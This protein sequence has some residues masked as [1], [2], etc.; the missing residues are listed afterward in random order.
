VGGE[1]VDVA[2]NG[3]I[4]YL[5]RWNGSAWSDVGSNDINS[6]VNAL[7]VY[8]GEL[9]VGG[10]FTDAAGNPNADYIAKWSGECYYTVGTEEGPNVPSLARLT[11]AHALAHD[12]VST[13]V[14]ELHWRT[15]YEVDHL[16]FHVYREEQGQRVRIT[17]ALIAGSALTAGAKTVLTAGQSYS[18]WDVL[19]LDSGPLRY[20]LEEIDLKGRRTWHG[21]VEVKAAKGHRMAAEP[22]RVR[23]VLLTRLG[24]GK[25]SVTAAPSYGWS[26]PRQASIAPPTP[27]Q[28][29]VQWQLAASFAL[30]LGVQAEG[31]YRVSRSELVAAG[32]DP[33]VDPRHFQLFADGVEVPLLV[34]GER[35][36]RFD[37]SDAIE[38]YG[39]GLDTAWT[40]TRTY[41]LVAGRQAGKRVGWVPSRQAGALAPLS[42]PAT[43]EWRPRTIFFA[44]LLNGEGENYFG[45]IVST[46][47]V[48]QGFTLAHL[49]PSAPGEAALEVTLQGITDG[50]HQVE[51]RLNGIAVGTVTFEGMAQGTTQV[52]LPQGRL[53]EG[54]NVVT[55]VALGGEMDYSLVASVRLTAWRL[56]QAEADVLEA[57]AQGGDEV[58]ISGFSSPQI[59]VLDVTQPD[60]VQAVPGRVQRARSG[61]AV[62]VVA[63]ESGSRTLLAFTD[64]HRALPAS[65][66]FNHPSQWHA[67]GQGADLVILTPAAL[68]PSLAPLQAWRQQQGWR[69][70][71]LDVQDVYDEFSFGAKSPWALRAFLQQARSQWARPPR[72]LLLAGDAS[73]DPRNFMEMGDMDVVPTKLVDT[74]YLETASDDW[75]GD[76]DE[77]GVPEIAVGR[78]AVQTSEQAAAVVQKLIAYDRAGA[79]GR[80]AVL[81]ADH[82][83]GFDFEGASGQL[84]ALLPADVTV[85][86]I[87]R[88]Q[89]GDG[90]TRAAVLASLN[91]GAWLLNY[92]GHGSV[93]VWLG[94]VLSSEDAR[95]LTN[96]V[97]LPFVVAMTCLNGFF[98]DVWSESLAEA[99]QKAPQGGAVAV[100]ASSALT[101]PP[102]QMPMNQA[103]MQRL[104][105]GVTLG[106]AIAHA[107]RAASDP[108]VRRSWILLGD[109]TTR[110]H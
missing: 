43:L 30:K 66:Q 48:E 65:I 82:D 50:L 74:R 77:D 64:G 108:D 37:P 98:H 22:E 89:M 58:T 19:P 44:A 5:A 62:T 94:G 20:W 25:A 84:K 70:A 107:K 61:F 21:P 6:K 40:D 15:S 63:P 59:R 36:G 51:I 85:E 34:T 27:E 55:L 87:S 1:F 106:E 83:D 103:L 73:V 52:R 80:A 81:V 100:W 101:D 17:P 67:G 72:F 11:Q 41:W 110:L 96:G 95:T 4:D 32:L 109:P 57:P 60:A 68:A 26:G 45:P 92:L 71:L 10:I 35:D 54:P 33:R 13:R 16:G 28:L 93:E 99:L 69:V 14:V 31:W 39:L 90:A 88:G 91:G 3:S 79:G 53:Q 23:S 29:A 49:D 8:N 78:L 76:L 2:G 12:G 9:Y 75:F 97:R 86:E 105:E 42:F 46:E 18:W 47:P 24:R 102:S 56:Y 38:F 7:A 104:G